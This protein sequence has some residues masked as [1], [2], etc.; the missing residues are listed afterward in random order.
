VPR[1]SQTSCSGPRRPPRPALCRRRG[2]ARAGER[3]ASK[4]RAG[5]ACAPLPA[6]GSRPAQAAWPGACA[7]ADGGLAVGAQLPSCMCIPCGRPL[8]AC[9]H[10]HRHFRPALSPRQYCVNPARRSP[11]RCAAACTRRPVPWRARRDP[12]IAGGAR[13]E[14]RACL[15]SGVRCGPHEACCPSACPDPW[16]AFGERPL[17]RVLT[18][19][20]GAARARA[21]MPPDCTPPPRRRAPF[22]LS[23][24]GAA[25]GALAATPHTGPPRPLR[26]RA[27]QSPSLARQSP[28]RHPIALS[29]FCRPPR[30]FTCPRILALAAA[31]SRPLGT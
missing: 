17:P 22:A 10:A 26:A 5:L 8:R 27:T 20:A 4:E 9:T 21:P 18:R 15:S 28:T 14:G 25:P 30:L 1:C 19:R 11:P 23:R 7:L 2:R 31:A 13:G 29:P 24:A 6:A 16:R 12:G 3:A